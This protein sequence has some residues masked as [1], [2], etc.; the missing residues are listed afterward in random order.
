M[1]AALRSCK[2]SYYSPSHHLR[3][4]CYLLLAAPVEHRRGV[5]YRAA[6]P[7]HSCAELLTDPEHM[8]RE[9]TGKVCGVRCQT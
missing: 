5:A 1:R 4:S 8:R 7:N 2:C 3:R 9:R 6:T